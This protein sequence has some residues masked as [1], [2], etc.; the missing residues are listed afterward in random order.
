MKRNDELMRDGLRRNCQQT[1]KRICVFCGS[2]PGRKP[3]FIQAAQV[4]GGALVARN[5]TL[6][7]GG[8]SVGVMGMLAKA[9][10]DAGGEVIGVITKGLFEEKIASQELS[11]LY[12]MNTMHERKS[13]MAEL[14]DGFIA[15]PGGLGTM[16]E[17]FEVL[18]WA[19]LGFHVKPCGLLNICHYYDYWLSFLDTMLR[20]QFIELEHREM[21]MSDEE[22]DSLLRKFEVYKPPRNNKVTWALE[23][24]RKLRK[25]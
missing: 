23:M 7:Y 3:E 10:L 25:T 12:V 19:Q 11:Q 2:S 8:A 4:L 24:T 20:E 13:K 18:T 17:F 1:M 21:V 22:P 15:M 14:S 6:V 16:E 9:T 5:I